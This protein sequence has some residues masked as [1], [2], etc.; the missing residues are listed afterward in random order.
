M[1]NNLKRLRKTIAAT[2]TSGILCSENSALEV[3]ISR[4]FFSR[5]FRSL[6]RSRLKEILQ[7]RVIFFAFFTSKSNAKFSSKIFF[8]QNDYL[9]YYYKLETLHMRVGKGGGRGDWI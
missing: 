6:L 3:I 8:S 9:R 2:N 5:K 4:P 1:K 7:K